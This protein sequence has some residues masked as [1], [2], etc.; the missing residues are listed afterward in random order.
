MPDTLPALAS[1][2]KDA[3][4][5]KLADEAAPKVPTQ[6]VRNRF[7]HKQF[8]Q[9]KFKGKIEELPTLG[10]QIE[11]NS[12]T[13]QFIVFRKG[14]KHYIGTTFNYPKD[15][16]PVINEIENPMTTLATL[17]PKIANIYNEFGIDEAT[18][19]AET[20]ESI[21]TMFKEEMKQFVS[22]KIKLKDNMDKLY[23]VVW[24]QC[25]PALQSDMKGTKDFKT[26]EKERDVV[27]LLASLKKAA[28]GVSRTSNTYYSM[29]KCL[30]S[31]YS[32]RQGDRESVESYLQRFESVVQTLKMEKGNVAEH[33]GLIDHE[34][35][36]GNTTNTREIVNEKFL[37]MSFLL[38]ADPNRYKQLW[39]S[40]ENSMLVNRDEYPFTVAAAYDLLCQYKSQGGN[41]ILGNKNKDKNINDKNV[42]VIFAQVHSKQDDGNVPPVAGY[43]GVVCPNTR[44]YICHNKGHAAYYCPEKSRTHGL[45]GVQV[46]TMLTQIKP[47]LPESKSDIISQD[48]IL[49]DSGS[50]VSSLR[51]P[52]LLE[53][54]KKIDETLRVYTNGG[55]KDYN[56]KGMMKLLPF[57]VYYNKNSLANILSLA[58]VC[59]HFRVTMDSARDHSLFV[60]V[61]D[62]TV[63]RFCR[64]GSGLYY[65]DTTSVN[66]SNTD[67][68]AYP[69]SLLQTVA[70][71]REV[72]S[73]REI[74]GADNA[75]ILQAHIGWPS[76]SDL[77]MYI[78]NNHLINCKVTVDDVNRAE[79]IYGPQIPML[80][81]K[82]VRQ[83]QRE[84][85][86]VPRVELPS[87]LLKRHPT[88]EIDMDFLFVNKNPF[89]YTKTKNVKFRAVQPQT[90]RGKKETGKALKR[91][92]NTIEQRGI[93]VTALNGDNEFDKLR[94]IM[95]PTPVHI[96]ARGEHLSRIERDIR[97]LKERARCACNGLPYKR[98]TKLMTQSMIEWLITCLNN[99]P[100]KEGISRNMSPAAIVLGRGKPDCKQLKI[101]IGSYAEVY[102]TTKNTMRPRSVAAIALRPS[103]DRGG[104]Y[105]Q[106]LR[107][108]KRI[109]AYQWKEL[110]IPDYV[111]E[112]VEEM[113]K[114]EKQPKMRN[115]APL[116]EWAPGIPIID[117]NEYT[118]DDDEHF[119]I[120]YTDDEHYN[121]N[122]DSDYEDDDNSVDD[123][124]E[125]SDEMLYNTD[126]SDDDDDD[127]DNDNNTD[128]S[129]DDDDDINVDNDN[130]DNDNDNNNIIL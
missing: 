94:E 60:H 97:T 13:D 14:I 52:D 118:L 100:S 113:A 87:P 78:K 72:F 121:S 32:L 23:E 40:L 89:F 26:K 12:H 10:T 56:E 5:S 90:G 41:R 130:D 54:I 74:E 2:S 67:I 37:A 47:E 28:S 21:A 112:R 76:T 115:G 71:N 65:L 1:A 61:S 45:Q 82:M 43:N 116:F 120:D 48:W 92:V 106:S 9:I 91:I 119:D 109:H 99:F 96:T 123:E 4:P 66:N 126:D 62:H 110:P 107:T 111:I 58:D 114:K 39:T 27:W 122:E 63:L 34:V 102:E 84:F 105:F 16:D 103:N 19:D 108:G 77:K 57:E 11:R 69:V 86:S 75:R 79:A 70:A 124:S 98:I 6:Q 44:C 83:I 8:N 17:L 101:S 31:F 59:D 55:F 125:D 51:N 73:K 129:D 7:N 18:A 117:D 104:Y 25:S 35:S 29:H 81:G 3:K 50:T 36:L 46:G 49:L 80:R 24:G 68:N 127:I 88:D 53:N 85:T 15:M 38:G 64:C 22:R 128:D 33:K 20:K 30:K 93:R 95:H 42:N